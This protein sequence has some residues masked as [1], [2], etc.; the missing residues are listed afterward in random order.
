MSKIEVKSIYKVFG[1]HPAKWLQAAQGGMSKEELLA[2]SGHTLGLRDISLSIDEGSIYVIM[3]LSGS[4]KS[5]LIRHFN[6]LIEPSAGQILVDGVDVVS[7]NKRD[8]ETFRQKKMSM[9]FQRFGCSRTARCWRT[10]PMAWR[11]RAWAAPS[12]SAGRATGWNRLAC[13]VSNSS[14]RT[15]CPAAC[16][17]A[18][19]WRARW[20]PTP[21]SC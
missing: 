20:P 2:K 16:S 4:G 8:L 9:V 6:R 18:W 5:T 15:S 11:C 13:R 3:G 17:S 14:I 21:R 1:P 10:P 12:A 19:A 7:L